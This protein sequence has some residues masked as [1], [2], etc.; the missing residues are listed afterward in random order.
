MSH[1]QLEIWVY[2]LTLNLAESWWIRQWNKTKQET[3][4]ELLAYPLVHNTTAL[5]QRGPDMQEVESYEKWHNDA[6]QISSCFTRSK[7]LLIH[8]WYGRSLGVYYFIIITLTTTTSNLYFR[9]IPWA[10]WCHLESSQLLR[11][12]VFLS[13]FPLIHS[14]PIRNKWRPMNVEWPDLRRLSATVLD[15]ANSAK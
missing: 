3:R 1:K 10:S 8:S 12:H 7:V 11:S 9:N 5:M 4:T 13:P 6:R 15:L 2:K 14:W